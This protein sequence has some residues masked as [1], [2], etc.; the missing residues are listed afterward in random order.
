LWSFALVRAGFS[1]RVGGGTAVGGGWAGHV[2]TGGLAATA[3]FGEADFSATGWRAAGLPDG[4]LAGG[5]LLVN[6]AGG[7]AGGLAVTGLVLDGCPRALAGLAG[8][9]FRGASFRASATLAPRRVILAD[10]LIRPSS[11]YM[12]RRVAS[13]NRAETMGKDLRVGFTR[14]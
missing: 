11:S 6:F 12:A 4:S 2:A 10:L 1:L 7:R 8:G 3:G 5:L 9:A 13:A 14:H